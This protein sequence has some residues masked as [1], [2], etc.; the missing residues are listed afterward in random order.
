MKLDIKNLAKTAGEKISSTFAEDATMSVKNR[1]VRAAG[2]AGAG[3]AGEG[4]DGL[5][6]G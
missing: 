1:V 4:T 5:C 3:A 2:A 6:G